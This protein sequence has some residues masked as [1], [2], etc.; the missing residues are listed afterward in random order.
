MHNHINVI[1]FK[2]KGVE[3]VG[4]N[5]TWS[6]ILGVVLL[7]AGILGFL[8]GNDL[9]GFAVNGMHNIVHLVTGALFAWAGFSAGGKN[10]K[11]MNQ[12]LGAI[13]LLVAIL[14]LIGVQF[15]MTLLNLNTADQWLH[16]ALGV[17]TAGAGFWGE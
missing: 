11:K 4:F 6:K 16:L 12:W 3:N 17:V 2:K 15:L 13:Y 1:I 10:S 14:G 9:Y 7:I 5:T 8:M